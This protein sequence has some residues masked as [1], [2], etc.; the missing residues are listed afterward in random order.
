MEDKIFSPCCLC[1][2]TM[3]LFDDSFYRAASWLVISRL[4]LFSE[5]TDSNY[6]IA[7]NNKS[8]GGQTFAQY[9]RF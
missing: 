3:L 8:K 1:S 9:C 7:Y 2:T 4:W 5:F 6:N